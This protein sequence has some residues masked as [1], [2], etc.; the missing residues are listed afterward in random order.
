V[1]MIKTPL[2]SQ[3]VLFIL[4]ILFIFNI[5]IVSQT[6]DSVSIKRYQVV[7]NLT[8]EE[9]RFNQSDFFPLSLA[10]KG[11]LSASTFRGMP[12]GFFEYGFEGNDFDNP[13]TGFFNEQWI[14]HWRIKYRSRTNFGDKEQFHSKSPQGYKPETRIVYFQTNLSFLDIDFSEY[15]S[16]S[17]YI[18]LSGSN[19]LRDGPYPS[20]YSRINLNTYQGQLHFKLFDRW[21]LDI[22]Y[23]KIRHR[24]HM[25]PEDIFSIEKDRFK[26]IANLGWFRLSGKLGENDSLVFIPNYTQVQDD[27]WRSGLHVRGIDYE[28]SRAELG[29]FHKFPKAFLGA[30]VNSR[31]LSSNGKFGYTDK[32]EGEGSVL[33]IGGWKNGSVDFE[34]EAGGYKHSEIGEAAQGAL[35]IGI[36]SKLFGTTGIRFFHK[37]QPVPL[38]WRTAQDTLI[39]PYAEK[40]LI[41]RQGI[42]FY[43]KKSLS[44][45]FLIQAEPFAYRARNYPVLMDSVW[46]RNTIKNYGVHFF[47]G[48]KLWRFWL[49]NDFT[50]NR[51]Y[52]EA[53]APEVNNVSTAKSSLS[54]FKGALKAD[55]IL[56]FHVLS[57]YRLLQFNRLLEN[58]TLTSTQVGPF[59]LADFKLQIHIS[60]FTLFMVWENML[61]EDYSIV[62]GNPYQF[63]LF[64]I[65][66]LWLLFN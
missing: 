48:L 31:Y 56:I 3:T 41:E 57:H 12:P 19:F 44:N 37:P 55:G 10:E 63:R 7:P 59:Y 42:S 24:F 21:D 30:R 58:Y 5:P 40:K 6:S 27:Y 54:L 39:Q 51:N 2:F 60:R 1:K 36:N 35:H 64:R 33:A 66:L 62:E 34:F 22:F 28:W 65:G 25:V 52:R 15:I 13:V 8:E 49:Q 14:V 26:Q 43:A 18:G 47:T 11:R 50:Y 16:K 20:S 53:F 38:S 23:W 46:E 45:W 29:Y 4:A 9:F 32:K 61:S 17:N